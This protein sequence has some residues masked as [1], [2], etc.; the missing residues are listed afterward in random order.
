MT[1]SEQ[2][3]HILKNVDSHGIYLVDDAQKWIDEAGM[4]IKLRKDWTVDKTFLAEVTRS[5]GWCK[6]QVGDAIVDGSVILY[7]LMT[8]YGVPS[9]RSYCGRGKQ[10]YADRE[11]LFTLL[12][13]RAL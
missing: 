8:H 3:Q 5:G 7:Y 12:S 13:E 1:P 11:T 4:A 6:L 9:A 10:H 2:C